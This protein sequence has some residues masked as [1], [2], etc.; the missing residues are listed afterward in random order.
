MGGCWLARR[1]EGACPH[2]QGR[3]RL[4]VIALQDDRY[5]VAAP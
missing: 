3:A 5:Q 1:S 4:A 2:D